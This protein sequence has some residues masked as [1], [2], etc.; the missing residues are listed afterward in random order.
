MFYLVSGAIAVMALEES[1]GSGLD[2]DESYKS[3]YTPL[4]GEHCI[5]VSE[6][7]PGVELE[8]PGF[9]GYRVLLIEDDAR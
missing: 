3:V 4:T 2:N 8:C 6:W 1:S 5:T 7:V 9:A